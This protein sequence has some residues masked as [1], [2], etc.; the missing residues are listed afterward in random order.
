MAGIKNHI[1]RQAGY[2]FSGHVRK[3]AKEV[4]K[5][6]NVVARNLGFFK[7]RQEARIQVIKQ[8]AKTAMTKIPLGVPAI[9]RWQP[10]GPAGPCLVE[11]VGTEGQG[12]AALMK[13][14]GFFCQEFG[15]PI[16]TNTPAQTSRAAE[17]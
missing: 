6:K 12:F 16:Q 3:Q 17:L 13:I 14:E 7:L 9:Q 15:F 8:R 2:I 10:K 11:Q 4:A 5:Q 1:G